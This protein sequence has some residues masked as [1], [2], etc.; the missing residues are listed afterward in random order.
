[1]PMKSH[2]SGRSVAISPGVRRIP[3]PIVLPIV[4]ASPNDS[5]RTRNSDR[6]RL[7]RKHARIASGL[8][9]PA[10]PSNGK[11]PGAGKLVSPR[12]TGRYNP[13]EPEEIHD[14]NPHYRRHLLRLRYD[15]ERMHHAAARGHPEHA[16]YRKRRAAAHA[17]RVRRSLV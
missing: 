13:A 12:T 1:M 15:P 5:P 7:M 2:G 10:A 4:T 14:A 9:S 17:R 6:G 16:Y 8:A 11:C 3:A